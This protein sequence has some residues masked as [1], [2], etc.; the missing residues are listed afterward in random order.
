[1]V[2]Y[3]HNTMVL[4]S[5]AHRHFTVACTLIFTVPKFP[6]IIIIIII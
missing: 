1:M 2:A 5:A 4:Q 6:I 3:L